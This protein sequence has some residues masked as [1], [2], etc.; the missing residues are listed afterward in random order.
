MGILI[1][2]HFRD[3]LQG[4]GGCVFIAGPA[5]IG[6]LM[7]LGKIGRGG[8]RHPDGRA[9]I[10]I[11]RQRPVGGRIDIGGGE[12][13]G[14]PVGDLMIQVQPDGIILIPGVVDDA[15]IILD[16]TSRVEG[17]LFV[18]AADAEPGIQ[19]QGLV[20][21]DLFFIVIVLMGGDIA[22][23]FIYVPALRLDVGGGERPLAEQFGY[24][25]LADILREIYF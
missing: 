14:D 19:Q 21:I 17:G 6:I 15:L 24:P 5:A 9:D 2:R 23:V 12:S 22:V 25:C 18:A 8:E 1:V 7:Q 3:R 10:V 16:G 4:I 20:A 11:I 13:H